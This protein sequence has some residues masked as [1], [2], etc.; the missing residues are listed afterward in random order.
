M[1]EHFADL[2]VRT[3]ASHADVGGRRHLQFAAELPGVVH[4]TL[5]GHLAPEH[6]PV[7]VPEILWQEGVDDGVDGGVAI[8]QAVSHHPEDEGGLVQGERA[9]LDPQVH[10]V[11]GQPGEAEDHHHNQDRLGCLWRRESPVTSHIMGSNHTL[12]SEKCKTLIINKKR[13]QKLAKLTYSV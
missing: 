1:S 13:E 12:N 10:D 3:F 8:G 9:E 4:R 5:A 7:G 11:V 2:R 6:L